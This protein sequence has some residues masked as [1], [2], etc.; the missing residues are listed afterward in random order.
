MRA[1]EFSQGQDESLGEFLQS[2]DKSSRI[3]ESQE[4]LL[5]SHCPEG[6]G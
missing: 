3:T 1:W 4:E 6:P 2:Q 5:T